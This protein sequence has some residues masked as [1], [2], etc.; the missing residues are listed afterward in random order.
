MFPSGQGVNPGDVLRWSGTTWQAQNLAG[1]AGECNVIVNSL[2]DLP[3]PSGGVITLAANTVYCFNSNVNLGA[4]GL[5]MGDGTIIQGRGPFSPTSSIFNSSAANPTVTIPP[6]V[7]T[8]TIRDLNIRNDASGGLSFNWA[9]NTS[10]RVFLLRNHF[11]GSSTNTGDKVAISGNG[12][13]RFFDTF[14]TATGLPGG[15]GVRITGGAPGGGPNVS[16][17]SCIFLDLS[18]SAVNV[19]GGGEVSSLIFG[20]ETI[21]QNMGGDVLL[22][23]AGNT[24]ARLAFVECFVNTVSGFWINNS[25]TIT[26]LLRNGCTVTTVPQRDPSPNIPTQWRDVGSIETTGTGTTIMPE[27]PGEVQGWGASTVNTAGI[28]FLNPGYNQIAASVGLINIR[29]TKGPRYYSTIRVQHNVVGAGSGSILYTLFKNGAA[30]PLTVS[31]AAGGTGFNVGNVAAPIVFQ[32][33]DTMDIQASA[34]GTITT[35]P[36]TVYATIS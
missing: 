16:F 19:T 14:F 5:V 30:T 11:Q 17:I 26:A 13:I 1:A 24:I 20:G 36:T 6:A 10:Q 12:I 33:G 15:G 32:D 29:Q 8:A 27:R 2:A 28:S 25:G 9:S 3:A 31:V 34:T 7:V 18:S 22:V 4:N 21:I 35:P 23:P